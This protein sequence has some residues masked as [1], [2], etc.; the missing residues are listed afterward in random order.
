MPILMT[1]MAAGLA[2]IPLAFGGGKPGSEIQTPMAIVILCGLMS[3]TL[4]NMVVVPTMYLRY[5]K[6]SPVPEA[7]PAVSTVETDD[8]RRAPFGP[9]PHPVQSEG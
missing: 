3:S 5:A 6:P 7:E 8:A 1:A 2:L 4:L 9:P